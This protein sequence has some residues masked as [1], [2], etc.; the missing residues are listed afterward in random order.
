MVRHYFA[1]L[2]FA[3]AISAGPG[4]VPIL[5]EGPPSV[6]ALAARLSDAVVNIGTSRRMPGGAGTPFPEL[7]EGSPLE[8]L[9]KEL[10]PNFGQGED[11]MREARSLGSG[12]IIS[13]DGLVVTNNHVIEGAD[14][15]LVYL[16]DQTRHVAEVVG[17]DDKTDIAVLRIDAGH[18]LPFVE[19]GNSDSA[20]VGDW[21]M[22][23]GNPFGLG[24]SVSLGIVSA[25]N[26]NINSGPYDN[27]IQTDA[28]INE[29]NSGGPLFDMDGYVVGINTAIVSRAGQSYGIGFAVPVNLAQPVIM[30]LSTFGETRRGWLGV[31]IQDMTEDLAENYGRGDA[32][33]ALVVEVTPGGPADGALR[34]GDLILA[35]NGVS[36][37]EMR[38]L[39]RVVAET[40]VGLEV[41][42]LV[43]RDGTEQEIPVTLGRLE[44][45]EMLI[46]EV[47]RENF[48]E[49]LDALEAKP[50][51]EDLEISLDSS[52][53]ELLGLDLAPLTGLARREI[54]ISARVDGVLIVG[55]QG[56]S[57]A[58][59]KGLIAGQVITEVNQS[60][61][62]S[63]EDMLSRIEE[64]RES[65]RPSVVL[66]VAD[67]SGR[68]RYVA[69]QLNLG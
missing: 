30:Q 15:I 53:R 41:P 56:G 44:L 1:V 40:T 22:A 59:L 26:R 66:R 43:L 55:V 61:I 19:L 7:P 2:S 63:I 29:G 33:G 9:F 23:I 39:Q 11:M 65:G 52:L 25:R 24:G 31:G 6:S 14:E 46:A 8:D 62:A 60:E 57:D 51:G 18:E 12:F 5:A 42:V 28:A 54:G 32:F 36:I 38:E 67:P 68:P 16:P 69:V 64:A 48:N 3:L 58:D 49:T 21:V 34:G 47:D 45:G 20:E 10:N 13:A 4:L 50:D 37:R 27:F 17:A 35:F